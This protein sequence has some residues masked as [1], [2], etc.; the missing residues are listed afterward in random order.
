M[1]C[2]IIFQRRSYGT[3][4]HLEAYQHWQR[5]PHHDQDASLLAGSLYLS[6]GMH[7]EA[8]ERFATLLGPEVPPRVRNRAWF[9]LAKVWYARGYYDK[10][11]EALGRISGQL[12]PELEPER[13]QLQV[14]ALMRQGHFA[15]AAALLSNW[16]GPADWAAFARFNLGVAL[17]RQDRL[18]AAEPV[19][20]A[21]GTLTSEQ[22]ELLALRDKANLALGYACLQANQPQQALTALSRVRLSG[23]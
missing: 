13:Q 18:D 11:L 16:Q 19:L 5:M 2:S 3:L 22:E 23:A 17:I 1:C 10:T 7:N 8:G 20:T 12:S 6:L 4:A 9:Y 15:E 21:V 14:T